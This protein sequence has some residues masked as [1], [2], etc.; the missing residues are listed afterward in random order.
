MKRTLTL[1]FLCA[2]FA[3]YSCVQ[4]AELPEKWTAE[5]NN[6]SAK[7]R[8]LQIIHGYYG[9]RIT[10][11]KLRYYKDDCGL[12]GLV[13]NVP[14]PFRIT[15]T[16]ASEHKTGGYL[17]NDDEWK[18]FKQLVSSAKEIG[19]RIWIYDED[20]YPSL[21][22]GGLVLEGHPELES[23]AL[24]YDKNTDIFAVRPAYEYTHAA[25]NYSAL[26]R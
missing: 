1:L 15:N 26:R 17:R 22:A 16:T 3:L 11:E 20:G 9:E 18:R 23:Q 14:S 2:F 7:N 6:P 4:A 12:G 24:V 13:V 25:S 21:G 5:W 10:P 19:L 8:P